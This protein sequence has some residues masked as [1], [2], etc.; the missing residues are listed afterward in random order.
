MPFKVKKGKFWSF[1]F[2][3]FAFVLLCA[4]ALGA[5]SMFSTVKYVGNIVA[6]LGII[7]ELYGII[8][9]IL[10]FLI[11]FGIVKTRKKSRKRRKTRRRR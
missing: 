1:I 9:V 3:L 2:R 11:Y 7:T 8:G 6:I 10:C 4:L 5:I